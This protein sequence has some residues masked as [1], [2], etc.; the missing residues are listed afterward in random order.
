[1][2]SDAACHAVKRAAFHRGVLGRKARAVV[3]G[4]EIKMYRLFGI[5]RTVVYSDEAR[6]GTVFDNR[7]VDACEHNGMV[8]GILHFQT[9]QCNVIGAFDS[10][11]LGLAA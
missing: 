9:G 2:G 7:S 6:K 3:E 4:Q 1:M 5:H 11:R 8:G 10:Y